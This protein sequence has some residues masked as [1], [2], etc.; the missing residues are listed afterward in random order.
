MK[1]RT[2]E[3]IQTQKAK[4]NFRTMSIFL[5]QARFMKACGQTVDR[6]NDKQ[7]AMYDNLIDEELAELEEAIIRNNEEETADAVID[8]IV[9]LIGYGLS[10][11]WPMKNLW[12]EVMS[13]NM[14]KIDPKTG[15]VRKRADGKV[16]KPKNWQPPNIKDVLGRHKNR[17]AI[18]I[19][20]E[21]EAK[22]Q[23][24]KK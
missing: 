3:E 9:V 4:H 15:K 24:K 21:A 17:M 8:S 12:D 16:L 1:I 5:Q 23:A 18:K 11:G 19:N 10:R 13:S 20:R 14:E 2:Q 7:A 6:L 22:K